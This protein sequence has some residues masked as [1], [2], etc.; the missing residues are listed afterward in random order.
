MNDPLQLCRWIP[1]RDIR[2]LLYSYLTN[3]EQ[4]VLCA[5]C[6][7]LSIQT[8]LTVTFSRYCAQHNYLLLLKWACGN[9]CPWDLWTCA[10]AAEGGHLEVLQW[11]RANGCPWNELTCS[12]AASNGH[13]EVLQWARANG[14]SWNFWTCANAAKGISIG[15]SI[16]LRIN[17]FRDKILIVLA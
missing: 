10:Y 8:R 1:Q 6:K 13:L 12:Y 9:G 4:L 16:K 11:A 5:V 2:N 7:P 17:K 15:V 14:C 3:H